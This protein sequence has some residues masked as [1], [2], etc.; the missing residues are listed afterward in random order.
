[1]RIAVALPDVG[2]EGVAVL[3][4]SR[5]MPGLSLRQGLLAD[6][7]L[8]GRA[9][10]RAGIDA[11]GAFRRHPLGRCRGQAVVRPLEGDLLDDD[12]LPTD[13]RLEL[14]ATLEL[15]FVDEGAV[16]SQLDD[17]PRA[18]RDLAGDVEVR[19]AWV[20]LLGLWLH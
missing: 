10:E 17:R 2:V 19:I 11:R 8:V 20:G 3:V 16:P 7:L 4:L 18:I 14:E 6:V 12:R 9:R 1:D 5:R 13:G 15:R